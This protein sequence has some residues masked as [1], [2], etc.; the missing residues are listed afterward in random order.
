MSEATTE[1]AAAEVATRHSGEAALLRLLRWRGTLHDTGDDLLAF[2]QPRQYFRSYATGDT[3]RNVA[4][5]ACAVFLHD[6]DRGSTRCAWSSSK[7]AGATGTTTLATTETT[8]TPLAGHETRRWREA[9]RRIET[10][11]TLATGC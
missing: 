11:R 3:D 9:R 7:A 1:I 2:R 6:S 5:F 8:G 4:G 10:S